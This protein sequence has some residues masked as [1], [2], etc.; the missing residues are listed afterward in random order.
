MLEDRGGARLLHE[1]L[2]PLD[3]GDELPAG[4]LSAQPRARAVY[5]RA[6]DGHHP[7]A[8]DLFEHLVVRDGA[9]IKDTPGFLSRDWR[10]RVGRRCA[11][12]TAA[13][14][15]RAR[16]SRPSCPHDRRDSVPSAHDEVVRR[17]DHR[18]PDHRRPFASTRFSERPLAVRRHPE[19]PAVHRPFPR[20]AECSRISTK[21]S[22]RSR[23]LATRRPADRESNRAQLRAVP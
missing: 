4:A 18:P 19:Q 1:P 14:A 15:P 12:G 13:L 16:N 23:C 21:P 2:P 8:A 17:N 7:A 22:G 9:P 3:C 5:R 20:G 11:A 6:V 10:R